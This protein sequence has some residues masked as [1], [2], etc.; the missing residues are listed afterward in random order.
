MTTKKIDLSQ[1][2]DEQL[3][4]E[5]KR[6]QVYNAGLEARLMEKVRG[7]NSNL[8]NGDLLTLNNVIWPFLF[9]HETGV[10][11]KNGG[12]LE[13]SINISRE[14]SFVLTHITKT[15]FEV[16]L[17]LDGNITNCEYIDPLENNSGT[18][19]ANGLMFEIEDGSSSRRFMDKMIPLDI[20]AV[21]ERPFVLPKPQLFQPSQNIILR[22][23]NEN[24][25]RHFLPFIVMHGVRVRIDGREDLLDMITT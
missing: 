7:S 4:Q 16:F 22:F 23:S 9:T 1:L 19:D 8:A 10:V 5:L 15:V 20:F 24:P 6:V 13:T 18:G 14:A 17:D 12:R 3:G 21:P 2:S 25:N 11:E